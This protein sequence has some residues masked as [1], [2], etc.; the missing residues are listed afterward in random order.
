LGVLLHEVTV[1]RA[2]LHTFTSA[3]QVGGARGGTIVFKLMTHDEVERAE[4]EREAKAQAVA[5]ELRRAKSQAYMQAKADEK[6]TKE[7]RM[8][9]LSG[10]RAHAE[11]YTTPNHT[12]LH[13]TRP[14]HTTPRTPYF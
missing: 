7:I 13:Q 12:T 2:R 1:L 3:A 11:P 5:E 8:T 10:E 4:H 14:D 6:I 9:A